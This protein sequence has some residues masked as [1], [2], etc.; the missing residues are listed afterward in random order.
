MRL[1]RSQVCLGSVGLRTSRSAGQR[2]HSPNEERA[3]AAASLGPRCHFLLKHVDVFSERSDTG[4]CREAFK[5]GLRGEAAPTGSSQLTLSHRA[6]VLT[7]ARAGCRTAQALS[8][9][10]A[11]SRRQGEHPSVTGRGRHMVVLS[12][13]GTAGVRSSAI[14]GRGGQLCESGGEDVD[15]SGD[16][17]LATDRG[18]GAVGLGE[19]DAHE[20]PASAE[21]DRDRV[22]GLT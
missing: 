22:L 5:P 4:P 13:R 14:D 19:V 21:V 2:T 8:S 17:G 10:R 16:G 6:R 3:P 20:G 18:L 11:A 9:V 1:E 15:D 12:G 7:T